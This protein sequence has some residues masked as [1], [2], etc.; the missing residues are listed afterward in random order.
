MERL[1]RKANDATRTLGVAFAGCT[2]PGSA[3]PLFTVDPTKM[4]IGLGIHGEPGIRT[5]DRVSA[6]EL[7]TLLV[8][9]LLAERPAGAGSRAAVLL[10]GLGTTK[11]E[12]LFVVWSTVARALASAGVEIVEPEVGE[13]VTSLDMA[14]AS[15]TLHWLDEELTELW[16]AG[17][18]T[19]GYRKPAPHP[20]GA[21][22]ARPSTGTA[23]TTRPPTT[24]TAPAPTG[25]VATGT[26]ATGT[27]ATGTGTA[28]T[29]P[30]AH[31]DELVGR[32]GRVAAAVVERMRAVISARE[33]ELGRLDAVAGDGDHGRGMVRGL[34]AASLAAAEAHQAGG[35]AGAVL[36][37]AGKGFD[38]TAGGASGALWGAMLRTVGQTVAAADHLD[39]ATLHRGL[40]EALDAVMRLGRAKP[41]DKTMLDALAP[42]VTALGEQAQAGVALAEAWAAA[43]PAA[44]RGTA[45]TADL[46][47]RRGR[48][49]ALA[50][51]SL[52]TP[53]PGATSLT[54]CLASVAEV[55]AETGQRSPAADGGDRE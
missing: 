35:G 52:G 7:A 26:V 45:A 33:D 36:A 12:E 49:A 11:Y 43:L 18:D 46:A 19:P 32:G 47:A 15:L 13:L 37:A 1:A 4:D 22:G 51:R 41:G 27:A 42:F 53:D 38:D 2:M 8:E 17:A 55:L 14:G 48:S 16:V 34:T 28:S 54:Y 5:V 10:N 39:T 3:E 40:A 50:E 44:E 31:P 6:A 21:T 25:T 20:T 23:A 30:P 29:P 9:P 24:P